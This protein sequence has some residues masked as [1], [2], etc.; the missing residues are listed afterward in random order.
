LL[1]SSARGVAE[2][3]R[4][5]RRGAALS[6]DVPSEMAAGQPQS[7]ALAPHGPALQRRAA[8]ALWLLFIFTSYAPWL[9]RGN[10]IFGGTKHW[11]TAYPFIA[12]LAGSAFIA[13]SKAAKHAL[14]ASLENQDATTA[15]IRAW[16]RKALGPVLALLVLIAPLAITLHSQPWGL[17]A[18]TPLVGGA[19]GAA[20]LGL[21]RS[22]WGYTTGAVQD[23]INEMSPKGAKVFVHDTALQS[24]QMMAKDGR[25]RGDLRAQLGVA[26][27]KIGIYHHEQHM[28]RVEHQ[29]W[30]DYGTVKPEHVGTYDGVP[31]VWL[32]KRP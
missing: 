29:L 14:V 16:G 1:F 23:E 17:A 30:V 26:Y 25:V 9:S 7:E 12:L 18:Y 11:M 22:F 28:S 3:V 21:N 10:P 2:R 5:W 27:S 31:I 13:C 32:Y 8:E 24:W 4:S 6:A 20:S 15:R 19:P